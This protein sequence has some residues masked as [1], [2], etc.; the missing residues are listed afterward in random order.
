MTNKA[1][2]QRF[3]TVKLSYQK[4][5]CIPSSKGFHYIK[6]GVLVFWNSKVQHLIEPDG[7]KKQNQDIHLLDILTCLLKNPRLAKKYAWKLYT[8]T[9][10]QWLLTEKGYVSLLVYHMYFKWKQSVLATYLPGLSNAESSRSGRLV[11]PITNTSQDLLRPSNSAKSWETTRSMTPPESPDLPRLG[12]KE[13]NSSKKMT[14]GVALLALSN[15]VT[16]C[17]YMYKLCD[18][19]CWGKRLWK[20]FR[21][22]FSPPCYM[23]YV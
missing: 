22:V 9:S 23:W 2:F 19:D 5:V 7:K 8:Y 6:F 11:A 17:K 1:E 15:T 14:Q 20:K 4:N 18:F 10:A 12:A 13:S 21:K 16:R 3:M